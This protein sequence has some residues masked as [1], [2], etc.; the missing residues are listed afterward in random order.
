MFSMA[1]AAATTR[2]ASAPEYTA[3]SKPEAKRPSASA[4]SD[5]RSH[6]AATSHNTE[7]NQ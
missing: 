4:S 5:N 6:M 1:P 2:A 3:A 7:S